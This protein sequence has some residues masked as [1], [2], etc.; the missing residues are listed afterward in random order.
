MLAGGEMVSQGSLEPLF[1][2]RILAR[3]PYP[4]LHSSPIHD[5]V[6]A[7]WCCPPKPGSTDNRANGAKSPW[8]LGA[9]AMLRGGWAHPARTGNHFLPVSTN[10]VA[11]AAC[12]AV[13]PT[14][15]IRVKETARQAIAATKL[16]MSRISCLSGRAQFS[17]VI[18]IARML[19]PGGASACQPLVSPWGISLGC[20]INE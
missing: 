18:P 2:V 13:S 1:Q 12:P 9:M 17:T 8:R 6:I 16:V 5:A 10:P 20:G 11:A 7:D 14:A 4:E 15:A 3:Q 19:S